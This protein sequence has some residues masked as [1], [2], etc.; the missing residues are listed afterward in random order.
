MSVVHVVALTEPGL[1]LS[2]GERVPAGVGAYVKQFATAREATVWTLSPERET[3]YLEG[4]DEEAVLVVA[5]T[6]GY[7]L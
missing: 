3:Y 2:P 4:S 1:Y 7:V 6:R 5:D